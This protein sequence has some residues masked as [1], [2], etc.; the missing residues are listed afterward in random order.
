MKRLFLLGIIIVSLGFSGCEKT[1]GE[2]GKA[3]ISGTLMVQLRERIADQVIAE[4]EARETRV[5][6]IY[7]DNEI[8]DDEVRTNFDGQY[9]FEFLYPGTYRIFAYSECRACPEQV[10]PVFVEVEVGKDDDF[11]EA[12]TLYVREY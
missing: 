12:P 10:N 3:T 6:I 2:G 9:K 8:Y 11:V 4:Y 7:G 5:Y 1:E